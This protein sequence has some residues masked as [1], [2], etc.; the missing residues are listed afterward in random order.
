MQHIPE[1]LT[2]KFTIDRDI[3]QDLYVRLDYKLL[4]FKQFI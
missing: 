1:V 2:N 3:Y 4:D